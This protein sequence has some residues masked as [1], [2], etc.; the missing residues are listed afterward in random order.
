[1]KKNSW[2]EGSLFILALVS[3]ILT[4]SFYV[5]SNDNKQ[6]RER[7]IKEHEIIHSFE[8]DDTI[9]EKEEQQ[10][11]YANLAELFAILC[12]IFSVSALTVHFIHRHKLKHRDESLEGIASEDAAIS[13]AKGVILNQALAVNIHT[14]LESQVSVTNTEVEYSPVNVTIIEQ[15]DE[16]LNEPDKSPIKDN[17][18]D[19]QQDVVTETGTDGP[20]ENNTVTDQPVEE[21][22]RSDSLD[23]EESQK[24]RDANQQ[25]E[26]DL[27]FIMRSYI[28]EKFRGPEDVIFNKL[29][30]DVDYVKEQF[31][32]RGAKQRLGEIATVLYHGMNGQIQTKSVIIVKDGAK[33]VSYSEWMKTFFGAFGIEQNDNIKK[34]GYDEFRLHL[35]MPAM[36]YLFARN[37]DDFDDSEKLKEYL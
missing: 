13:S 24:T 9:R 22:G 25:Y 17:S 28:W 18:D 21:A 4:A 35:G 7:L 10:Q 1:M 37:W 20:D 36:K 19:V 29:C 32:L 27:R 30:K 33:I 6:D 23:A 12:G 31:K 16:E 5:A 34:D 14:N 11:D 3:A 15:E 8:A 2:I 26:K